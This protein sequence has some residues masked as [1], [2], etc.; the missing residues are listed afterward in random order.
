MPATILIV[1]ILFLNFATSYRATFFTQS[2]SK[3]N[4]NSSRA[5]YAHMIPF[6]GIMYNVSEFN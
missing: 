3:Q 4:I 5:I 6:S 1:L 2:Y